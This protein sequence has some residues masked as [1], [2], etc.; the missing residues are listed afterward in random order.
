MAQRSC[1]LVHEGLTPSIVASVYIG[2]M[3]LFNSVIIWSQPLPPHRQSLLFT[4]AL[5][6]F[7]EFVT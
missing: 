5:K 3:I 2:F 4:I 6:G 7:V 1:V